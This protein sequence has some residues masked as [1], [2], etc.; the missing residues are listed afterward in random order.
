MDRVKIKSKLS[1][2]MIALMVI[3]ASVA[4]VFLILFIWSYSNP[5][6]IVRELAPYFMWFAGFVFV[7]FIFI[8]VTLCIIEGK[9]EDELTEGEE[10]EA[11]MIIS[12]HSDNVRTLKQIKGGNAQ[13]CCSSRE[14]RVNVIAAKATVETL[15]KELASIEIII[16]DESSIQKVAKMFTKRLTSKKRGRLVYVNETGHYGLYYVLK[17]LSDEKTLL[18]L[19]LI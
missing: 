16:E 6:I 8:F 9:E 12:H 5:A 19:D 7:T 4:L 15:R 11:S 17:Y 3:T 13:Y 10:I 1:Y 14:S 18:D 2:G